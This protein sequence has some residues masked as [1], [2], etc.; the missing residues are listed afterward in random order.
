MRLSVVM[1][2][3]VTSWS[4]LGFRSPIVNG[5]P[6]GRGYATT[7]KGARAWEIWATSTFTDN[8]LQYQEKWGCMSPR[9]GRS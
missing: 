6:E 8:I 7:F 3:A 9:E 1:G 5:N 4:V 2:T